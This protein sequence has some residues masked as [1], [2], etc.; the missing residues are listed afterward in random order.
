MKIHSVIISVLSFLSTAA[1]ASSPEPAVVKTVTCVSGN[2]VLEKTI[3]TPGNF[4]SFEGLRG[5][6]QVP[7]SK[8]TINGRDAVLALPVSGNNDG[9]CQNN[10]K[11]TILIIT[12]T[13]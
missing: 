7:G 2:T 11:E 4:T 9:V 5:L 13:K 8:L 12:A 6:T 1:M 3:L 10:D